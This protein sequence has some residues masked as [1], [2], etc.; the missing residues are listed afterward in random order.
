MKIYKNLLI[1]VVFILIGY[2]GFSQGHFNRYKDKYVVSFLSKKFTNTQG[3]SLLPG[4]Y[5]KNYGVCLNA[6]SK[7]HQK[8][9]GLNIE[10]VGNGLINIFTF[11]GE[12]SENQFKV[13][14][15]SMYN[16]LSISPL[17]LNSKGE[18]NGLT[19]NGMLCVQTQINGVG[20][21]LLASNL[22]ILKGLNICCF[23]SIGYLNG[24][25]LGLINY[26]I[27]GKGATIG[28]FNTCQSFRGIMIGI[29]NKVGERSYPLVYFSL[30]KK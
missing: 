12:Y 20:L 27:K 5:T 3:I 7:E 25:Q 6:F 29:M 9:V 23:S 13:K 10:L 28:L 15:T 1:L 14:K 21:S 2:S 17:G 4:K 22:M 18:V 8:N 24:L 26:S 16:G 30:K 19:I 11:T